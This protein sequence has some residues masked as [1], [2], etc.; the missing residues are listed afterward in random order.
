MK[1]TTLI[2]SCLLQGAFAAPAAV[3]RD[4]P[5]AVP[6]DLSKG[7]DA[8]AIP[9]AP[10]AS[11]SLTESLPIVKR[12]ATDAPAASDASSASSE[13]ISPTSSPMLAE[14]YRPT[15]THVL[16][17]PKDSGAPDVPVPGASGVPGAPNVP[18]PVPVPNLPNV[19]GTPPV[20]GAGG[21]EG[22]EGDEG[23]GAG[24]IPGL[25]LI[26]GLLGGIL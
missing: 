11:V 10:P 19:P 3:L 23:A 16:D 7:S 4:I 26:M 9:I 14:R 2:L 18:V 1:T 12:E 5:E 17:V 6:S 8:P 15:A 13:A 21:G 22:G 20:P 25:D 24:D